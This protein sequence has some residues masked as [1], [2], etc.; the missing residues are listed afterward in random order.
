V[1]RDD[2]DDRDL[3]HDVS[4]AESHQNDLIAEEFPEGPYGADL[5]SKSLGKSSPWR[6]G[7]HAQSP[8]GYEN[9]SLHKGLPRNYPGED[10]YRIGV[11]EVHDEP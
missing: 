4:T 2:I 5:V 6:M 1:Y 9:K 3:N 8:Y 10:N 7:Q 11:P